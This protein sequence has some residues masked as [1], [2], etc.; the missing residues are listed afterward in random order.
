MSGRTRKICEAAERHVGA[1]GS[2]FQESAHLCPIFINRAPLS[3]W[4]PAGVYESS[5]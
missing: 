1:P 4:P 5:N 2:N 3:L